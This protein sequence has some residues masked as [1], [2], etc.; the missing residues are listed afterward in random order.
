MREHGVPMADERRNADLWWPT[1]G[2]VVCL[3]WSFAVTA[4][5][6]ASPAEMLAEVNGEAIT[7][8]EVDKSLGAPL[9]KLE[10]QMF[11]LKRQRVAALID[12]RLLAAEAAK[13]GISVRE[14][15]AQEVTAKVDAVTDADVDATYAELKG[16]LQGDEPSV[17]AQVRSLLQDRKLAARRQAYLDTLR[18]QAKI[19]VN[20]KPP[21]IFRAEVGT[22]G[23]PFKGP[24]TAQVTLVEFQDFHCPFCQRVQPTLAQVVERYGDRVKV[25][26]RD[27]PIDQLHPQARKAH[28]AAR[29]ANDQGK[30]WAYHDVLYAKLPKAGAEELIAYAQET[31]LDLPQFEQCIARRTHRDDVQKDIDDG[32]RAGVT[33]TP[34]FFINGR[35]LSGA[36][37]LQAFAR[38]IDEEL[39]R[40]P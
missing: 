25:V 33:G 7:A 22:E 24:A 17:R 11:M 14:L 35:P 19:V 13:R 4:A 32:I 26:Y 23:A 9:A 5:D 18:S 3:L 38:V 28:E 6:M 27:F 12:E 29:C 30:F 2:L 21:K 37:P 39:A 1:L 36:L 20:M 16:Q 10:E 15:L 40:A 34:T 31:G 8:Q